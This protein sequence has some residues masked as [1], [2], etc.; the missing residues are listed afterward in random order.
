MNVYQE[1]K[2]TEASMVDGTFIQIAP[3]A[4]P[5]AQG[6]VRGTVVTAVYA[7]DS[8]GNIWKL[9]DPSGQKWMRVTA[10]REG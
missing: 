4:L 9:M 3:V 7:L 1:G 6:T 2:L 10:E 5:I 8:L